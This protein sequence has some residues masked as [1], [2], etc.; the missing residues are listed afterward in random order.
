M[1]YRK[2]ARIV[3]LVLALFLSLASVCAAS[4]A[5]A[6]GI[7]LEADSARGSDPHALSTIVRF[8]EAHFFPILIGTV[9]GIALLYRIILVF[10]R[11][12]PVLPVLLIAVFLLTMAF[13]LAARIIGLRD[14]TM[15]HGSFQAREREAFTAKGFYEGTFQDA[16]DGWYANHFSYHNTL[17]KAYGQLRYDAFRESQANLVLGEDGTIFEKGYIDE[18]LL[19]IP[20]QSDFLIGAYTDRLLR[21]QAL[22][23]ARGIDMALIITPSKADFAPDAIPQRFYWQATGTDQSLE[24]DYPRLLRALDAKGIVYFDA[25]AY[26]HQLDADFPLFAKTGIHW[27]QPATLY[28]IDAFMQGIAAPFYPWRSITSIY[29]FS[30]ETA[31]YPPDMDVYQLMNI[32]RGKQDE[33]YYFAVTDKGRTNYFIKPPNILMQGGSFLD[34][35]AYIFTTEKLASVST[36]NYGLSLRK[37]LDPGVSIK[38]FADVDHAALLGTADIVLIELNQQALTV[39]RNDYL[40]FLIGYLENNPVE[41]VALDAFEAD[42]LPDVYPFTFG[43]HDAS[44]WSSQEVIV[45]LTNEAFAQSG[46]RAELVVPAGARIPLAGADGGYA[47]LAVYINNLHVMDVALDGEDEAVRFA[48]PP[49]LFTAADGVYDIAFQSAGEIEM[50]GL[51]VSMKLE[52]LGL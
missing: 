5:S 38:S 14:S 15:L 40:D 33:R 4:G 31:L 27:T 23:A 9:L 49:E 52:Y 51:R 3:L 16:F 20:P 35:L 43:M 44:G 13:P 2:K 22:L 48:L 37:R 32:F 1:V 45:R 11:R 39:Y 21:V 46:A 25:P 29:P 26:L 30:G 19:L 17:Y 7:R 50:G 42:A 24:R 6:E 8:V 36:F 10:V 34:N 18:A 41:Q 28:C 12:R 47:P